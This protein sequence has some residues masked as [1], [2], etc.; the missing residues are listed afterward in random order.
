MLISENADLKDR[1][2]DNASKAAN[3]VKQLNTIANSLRGENADL[4]DRIQKNASIA[5]NKLKELK[6]TIENLRIANNTLLSNND[7]LKDQL[8]HASKTSDDKDIFDAYRRGFKDGFEMGGA[9]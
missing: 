5:D 3:E 2:K 8:D 6:M 4:K 7:K 9:H 1:I